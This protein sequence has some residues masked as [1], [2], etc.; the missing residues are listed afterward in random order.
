MPLPDAEATAPSGS[1]E[2]IAAYLN[3]QGLPLTNANHA[4]ALKANAENPG[5]IAGLRNMEPISSPGD[6]GYS[7]PP[8]PGRGAAGGGAKKP[9]SG[10]DA[11]GATKFPSN[12]DLAAANTPPPA[13]DGSGGLSNALIAEIL[14][15]GAT[16]LGAN[17]LMRG[18]GAPGA[19]EVPPVPSAA[20]A[21]D[22]NGQMMAK[23]LSERAGAQGG[24]GRALATGTPPPPGAGADL[25]IPLPGPNM[26]QRGAPV[27]A[28]PIR[29]GQP[30]APAESTGLNTMPRPQVTADVRTPGAPPAPVQM[31][32]PGGGGYLDV[33]QNII[34]SLGI[35]GAPGSAGIRPPRTVPRV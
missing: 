14:L 20:P 18:R 21:I 13:T 28:A 4:L 5:T 6:P 32:K 33:L 9:A 24:W 25:G 10:A 19:P 17:R 30:G 7:G 26:G 23:A 27:T 11:R 12:S 34:K 35:G 3:K 1:A 15:G 29:P 22:P 8:A 2:L 16:G 31:A